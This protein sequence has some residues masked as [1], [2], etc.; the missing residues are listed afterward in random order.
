MQ[1]LELMDKIQRELEDLQNSQ[2]AVL[3][4][5]TQIAAQNI[6]L[7]ESLLDKKLPD[8]QDQIDTSVITVN[9]LTEAFAAQ[10]EKFFTD[11]KL[12][13]ALNPTV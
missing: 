2:T 1:K 4:K 7:G 6:T 10:R 5:I 13:A 11:N 3:K 9:E 12:A 8:L